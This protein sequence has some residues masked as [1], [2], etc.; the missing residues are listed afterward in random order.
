MHVFTNNTD[1]LVATDILQA[2]TLWEALEWGEPQ[3][4]VEF[5]RVPDHKRLTIRNPEVPTTRTAVEWAKSADAP[6]LLAVKEDGIEWL[7]GPVWVH[8]QFSPAT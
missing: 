8:E 6:G 4:G 1:Y 3:P 2:R 5:E 7:R